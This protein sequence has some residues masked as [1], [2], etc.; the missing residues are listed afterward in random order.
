MP[1][2][3]SRM[4][5]IGDFSKLSRVTV[6]TLRYYDQ[7]GLLKPARVDHFTGYRYY[8]Y[9]QL[10]RLNRILALKDLGFS[11][12]EIGQ[13]LTNDLTPEQMRGMLK[14]RQAEIRQCVQ[15]ET[16]RFANA[17]ARNAEQSEEAGE[18]VVRQ[19]IL[20][21]PLQGALHQALDVVVGKEVGTWPSMGKG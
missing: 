10:P 7:V 12:E 8:T 19:P 3:A 5:R 20:R 17:Q 6:K 1:L 15:D 2:E 4:I 21:G 13:F 11:L 16:E 14:L 9:E 18:G